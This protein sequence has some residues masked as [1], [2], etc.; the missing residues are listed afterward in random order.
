MAEIWDLV[1]KNFLK[2]F[3]PLAA[4]VG[5]SWA[6]YSAASHVAKLDARL[7][8]VEDQVKLLNA[9]PS[10]VRSPERTPPG[11][12]S[13]PSAQPTP[14]YLDDIPT[15]NPLVETCI[16]LI[17]RNATAREQNNSVAAVTLESLQTTYD[18]RAVLKSHSR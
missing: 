3:L 8:T 1:W 17:K 16:D 9:A 5:L 4:I 15:S 18:C 11:T 12:T 10:I 7:Q 14:K 13:A 6:L 2:V